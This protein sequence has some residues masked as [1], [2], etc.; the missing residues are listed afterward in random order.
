MDS[1][2]TGGRGQVLDGL[3]QPCS[4]PWNAVG[5]QAVVVRGE[6]LN[7]RRRSVYSITVKI[8]WLSMIPCT[9]TIGV[10]AASTR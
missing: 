7:P 1:F 2:V 9:S 10:S 6:R 8:A 3:A 5:Q 4:G